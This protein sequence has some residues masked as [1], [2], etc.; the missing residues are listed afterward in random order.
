MQNRWSDR[1]VVW[2]VPGW[3]QGSMY[4]M[5]VHTKYDWTV[6]LRRRCGLLSN[7]FDHSL[8]Y[9]C[10]GAHVRFTVRRRCTKHRWGE[11]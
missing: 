5:E 11:L 4:R 2:D 6:H 7:Y 1:D 8:F 10:N 9:Y 3:A